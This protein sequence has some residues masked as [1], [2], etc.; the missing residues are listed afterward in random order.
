MCGL[1]LREHLH[2]GKDPAEKIRAGLPAA[3]EKPLVS[4][5]CKNLTVGR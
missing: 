2:R 5:V 3:A 4:L 1:Q